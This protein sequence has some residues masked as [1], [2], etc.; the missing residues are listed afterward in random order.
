MSSVVMDDYAALVERVCFVLPQV[1]GCL[2]L[3]EDGMV[4]SEF[5]EE[6]SETTHT[7]WRHFCSLDEPARG[8]LAFGDQH[9]A[10]V[11]HGAYAV[12]VVADVS[13]RPGVMIDRIE[14]TLSTAAISREAGTFKLPEAQSPTPVAGK[15]VTKP[16]V[17]P[18]PAPQPEAPEPAPALAQTPTPVFASDAPSPSPAPKKGEKKSDKKESKK[19]DATPVRSG[20][21]SERDP[22]PA[23]TTI[24]GSQPAARETVDVGLWAQANTSGLV[25]GEAEG[26][27]SALDE[28]T[29]TP[30]PEAEREPEDEREPDTVTAQSS[31]P[32]PAPADA[33][34]GAS[35]AKSPNSNVLEDDDDE[36]EVDRFQLAQEFSGLLQMDRS[37]D[38]G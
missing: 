32:T 31:R 9:W 38:E 18:S 27:A 19:A 20:S 3:S 5:P 29:L 22:E 25:D 36:E 30:A 10:Y 2:L 1:F 28:A 17:S 24:A 8:F 7:A 35:W 15:P 13:V 37:F 12:F 33:D 14:Q 34:A 23:P 6:G 26:A 21:T 16:V 11:R 4:L